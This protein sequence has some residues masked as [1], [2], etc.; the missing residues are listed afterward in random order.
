MTP[1]ELDNSIA[2]L[3]EERPNVHK[4]NRKRRNKFKDIKKQARR[5]YYQ[6]PNKIVDE[7]L[8]NENDYVLDS[9]EIT[10][11]PTTLSV[12]VTN[13]WYESL[14]AIHDETGIPKQYIGLS[15]IM[16]YDPNTYTRFWDGR[17]NVFQHVYKMTVLGIYTN[18]KDKVRYRSFLG[19]YHYEMPI[20]A[21]VFKYE[22]A[23]VDTLKEI[24][25]KELPL[26]KDRLM[27]ARYIDYMELFKRDTEGKF[28]KY[29]KAIEIRKQSNIYGKS[30]PYE[31]GNIAGTKRTL[32]STL[33]AF[34]KI[35]SNSLDEVE[36]LVID[37]EYAHHKIV[38]DY[39]W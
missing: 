16:T 34:D 4:V 35:D 30:I 15:K 28:D 23:I 1:E 22:G 8:G 6:V 12:G 2:L 14:N 10:Y 32:I 31:K 29:R 7:L 27:Y 24:Y 9:V 25:G 36:D 39:I 5:G 21:G 11:T 17:S 19:S 3:L 37:Y 20:R 33:N 26:K 18:G 38:Y 13:G